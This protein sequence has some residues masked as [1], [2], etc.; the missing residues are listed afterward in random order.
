VAITIDQERIRA[1]I[2]RPSEGLNVEIK[3]WIDPDDAF[4]IA[5]IVRAAFA[6]RNRNG[7]FFVLGFDNKTLL[8][9]PGG[10]PVDVR[11]TF[12]LDKIQGIVSHYASEPFEI[13]VAFEPRD[14]F[15]H[16]VMV[17]PQGVT[18]PVA[19]TRRLESAGRKLIGVGDVYARTLRANGT[20][21]TALARPEDWREIVD[22]CFE[23][24]E[25]DIGRFVRRQ[26]TALDLGSL[27]TALEALGLGP[28]APP[29]TP[30]LR[31]RA[32][33]VLADGEKRY[34]QALA[35]RTI[36][37]NEKQ[38]VQAGH[39]AVALI[40]DPP[41]AGEPADRVFLNTVASVDP[42]YTGW[43]P[44]IDSRGFVDESAQPTW[45]SNGWE[46][47]IISPR[48]WSQ[49]L[50]FWRL[51]P[52]G[53]FY[54]LRNLADD[55]V[56]KVS[57]RTALDPVLTIR[58]V[59]EVIA[60]GIGIIRALKWDPNQTRL[61]FAFRWTALTGRRLETWVDPTLHVRGGTAR[62]D[63]VITFVEVGLDTPAT[64]LAPVVDQATQALFLLFHGYRISLQ[65]IEALV[66][67]VLE[68][69]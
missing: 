19:A 64:A 17:I 24:R 31:D 35:N 68:R 16:A 1:L 54:L 52:R 49:H 29:P 13:G 69:R 7:G 39:W 14:G 11:G 56:D 66:R 22:I 65:A 41:K 2:S 40:V 12:H 57:P 45:T 53:E 15:D 32:V 47:L 33:A 10:R 23:N 48:A 61:G 59:T 50:D 67:R 4:G 8:P 55:V 6:L 28:P 25:A 51:D 18:A 26:L 38:L 42:S 44:W 36:A 34:R 21:S 9:H 37:E 60:V 58:Q 27:R 5:K 62:D 30:T 46:A 43:P 63:E 3:R 20:P